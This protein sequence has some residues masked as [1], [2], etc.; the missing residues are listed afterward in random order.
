MKLNDLLAE[1]TINELP[2]GIGSQI[3]T[4]F[5]ALN[6]FSASGRAH[7][8]GTSQT[9]K[10]ANDLYSEYYIWI[11]QRGIP[12]TAD[13]LV[14]FLTSKKFG[15]AAIQAAE[16]ELGTI[17][18]APKA[19]TPPDQ[20]EP[21]L[22]EDGDTVYD[23]AAIGKAILAAVQKNYKIIARPGAVKS[24]PAAPEPVATQPAPVAMPEP[25]AKPEMSIDSVVQ[26]Y[27][28][29][30]D[31]GKDELKAALGVA[32]AAATPSTPEEPKAEP[33][34]NFDDTKLQ[35]AVAQH[36][37]DE[38]WSVGKTPAK[39]PKKK[40]TTPA[41]SVKTTPAPDQPTPAPEKTAKDDL[42]AIEKAK[43]D[44]RAAEK[45]QNDERRAEL[46]AQMSGTSRHIKTRES[47]VGFSKF[48][49]RTL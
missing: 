42:A 15:A 35:K 25:E 31:K 4:G 13:S 12:T 5:K 27:N 44:A 19:T 10:V 7:A 11:G 34:S 39:T 8:Q 29:L 23:K 41:V 32:P 46:A 28:S 33:A 49:G 48:L 40:K 37:G 16:A 18:S 17:P 6:P 14:S 45:K 36:A 22:S 26:F 9:A 3:K 20:V 21:T 2:V 24:K 43:Q 1:Q 30:D 47:D 38:P